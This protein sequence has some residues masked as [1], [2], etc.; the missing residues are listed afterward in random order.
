M[1]RPPRR[2]QKRQ[3]ALVGAGSVVTR[4]IPA[5]AL[6]YGCPARVHGEAQ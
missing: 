2:H 4:D 3:H 5:H 1:L 6:A